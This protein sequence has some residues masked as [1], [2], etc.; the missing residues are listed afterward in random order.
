MKSTGLARFLTVT[1]AALLFSGFHAPAANA[2]PTEVSPV[3]SEE[4]LPMGG[5]PTPPRWIHTC[6]SDCP[7]IEWHGLRF[8]FLT[9]SQ[10]TFGFNIAV[11]GRN[12]ELLASRDVGGD[13]RYIEDLEVLEDTRQI[14]AI[15]QDRTPAVYSWDQLSDIAQ[16]ADLTTR[17]DLAG[18][19]TAV[20]LSSTFDVTA[21]VGTPSRSTAGTVEFRNGGQLLAELDLG[22][23]LDT[24][25]SLDAE[26]LGTGTFDITATYRPPSNGFVSGSTSDVLQVE[27]VAD[28]QVTFIDW[29]TTVL[30]TARVLDG[31]AAIAPSAPARPGYAFTGWDVD[32]SEVTGELT[33][34]AEYLGNPHEVTFDAVGGEVEPGSQTKSFD[35]TY[36]VGADGETAEPLPV[37]TR[38]GYHFAGWFTEPDGQG[39]LVTDESVVVTAGDH[40]L[41][42]Q[43]TLDPVVAELELAA[44]VATV[45]EGGSVTFEVEA[46]NAGGERLAVGVDEVT[47]S[48]D[49]AT[50]VIDGHT[51]TFPTASAH[52]I[53]ATHEATGTTAQVVI[54]VVAAEEGS[55]IPAAEEVV[56]DSGAGDTPA[57]AGVIPATGGPGAGWL[58]AALGVIV[59]GAALL[60]VSGRRRQH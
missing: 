53:T 9:S 4:S 49:V 34:R 45:D 46:F 57:E 33:V 59:V 19:A 52:T 20:G 31:Q 56:T 8:Y 15:G 27:V 43:W 11:Y 25:L 13:A 48:S 26:Q 3:A 18:P 42:A 23:D 2:D 38:A 7:F 1:V 58:L 16:E 29:D 51:V 14:R 54:E 5:L 21:T 35:A 32:F 50:D 17:T 55:D 30:A 24:V 47:L 44:S 40:S 12:R 22:S 28:H 6:F 37:P 39:D 41:Y 10:N 60:I 36:G